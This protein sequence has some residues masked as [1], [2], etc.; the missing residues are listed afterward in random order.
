MNMSHLHWDMRN[1]FRRL[2]GRKTLEE[3]R[4]ERMLMLRELLAPGITKAVK[5]GLTK[6]Y[7]EKLADDFA[8]DKLAVLRRDG[9]FVT[10]NVD[11]LGDAANATM[12]FEAV[13]KQFPDAELVLIKRDHKTE[14]VAINNGN[15]IVVETEGSFSPIEMNSIIKRVRK[16]A[17]WEES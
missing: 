15:L 11:D 6:Q 2:T 5:P 13:K 4:L 12:M 9:S 17:E 10:A 16:G 7:F 14:V 8:L 3:E 1:F